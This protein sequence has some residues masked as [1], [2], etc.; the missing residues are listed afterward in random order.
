MAI[1]E[2]NGELNRLESTEEDT[3]RTAYT[4]ALNSAIDFLNNKQFDIARLSVDQALSLIDRGQA[5]QEERERVYLIATDIYKGL[6]LYDNAIGFINELIVADPNYLFAYYKKVMIQYERIEL[7][8][9]ENKEY[10]RFVEAY[11]GTCNF[12]CKKS[13]EQDGGFLISTLEYLSESYCNHSPVDYDKAEYYAKEI[14]KY[15]SENQ[16]ARA[17]LNW[18][19]QPKRV[20]FDELEGYQNETSEFMQE[21]LSLIRQIVESGMPPDCY[22][23]WLLITGLYFKG[24]YNPDKDGNDTE[25]KFE[26]AYYLNTDGTFS[27]YVVEET[28]TLYKLNGRFYNQ[29]HKEENRYSCELGE[30]LREMDFEVSGSMHTQTGCSKKTNSVEYFM[31]LSRTHIHTETCTIIRRYRKKGQ[32]LY[33]RLKDISDKAVA[34]IEKYEQYCTELEVQKENIEK[35]YQQRR[36]LLMIARDQEMEAARKAG[37]RKPE[38]QHNLDNMQRELS[39]L[40]IFSGKRKKELQGL[41]YLMNQELDRLPV[42]KEIELRY[43]SQLTEL[44]SMEESKKALM[45]DYLNKKYWQSCKPGE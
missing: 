45:S 25:E 14:Q 38:L 8:R 32:G 39:S 10:S 29:E 6:G 17:I 11:R 12:L 9:S 26:I 30:V 4:T 13:I 24:W 31:D 18:L 5:F 40:G 7:L 22:L 41:I 42:I 34:Y 19:D 37:K 33:N 23:G 16:A 44:N 20:G 21:I 1:S 27:R 43:E 35:E 36:E 3:D 2:I 15:D 28:E